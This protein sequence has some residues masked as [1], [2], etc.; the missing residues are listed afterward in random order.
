[1]IP[2][3]RD[4]HKKEWTKA[5][6]FYKHIGM[7]AFRPNSLIEFASLE[8]TT[9][10]VAESLEQNRWLENGK[11][12]KVA[13]TESDSVGVDTEEDVEKVRKIIASKIK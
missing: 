5:H 8:Q 6:T 1:V 12:I 11:K 4:S 13:I 2:F 10:E 3:V 7:Y 9:L